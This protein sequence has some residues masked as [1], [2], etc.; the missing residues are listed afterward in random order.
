MKTPLDVCSREPGSAPREL[1]RR[2]FL[3]ASGV[4]L[5][6]AA[7]PAARPAR[8]LATLAVLADARVDMRRGQEWTLDALRRAVAVAR[9][10]GPAALLF[11]GGLSANGDAREL[12][13]GAAALAEA[14]LPVHALP[15][16]LDRVADGGRAWRTRFGRLPAAL[17]LGGAHVLLLDTARL[18]RA[19]RERDRAATRELGGLGSARIGRFALG[20]RQSAWLAARLD[21]GGADT[22]LVVASHVPLLPLY[23]AWNWGVEDGASVLERLERRRGVTQLFGQVSS[24]LRVTSSAGDIAQAIPP[25]ARVQNPPR[26][27]R[28]SPDVS[29]GGGALEPGIA[30]LR[31]APDREP[32]V[33]LVPLQDAVARTPRIRA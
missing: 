2:R 22:P 8:E 19:T 29:L 18:R 25:I 28:R 21:E 16:P 1:S 12:E 7:L 31:L 32:V 4:A 14:Q 17:V 26:A 33:E 11:L 10:H 30:L 3:E 24:G 23:S 13:L 5:A 20:A 27:L 6:F 15:G 9:S